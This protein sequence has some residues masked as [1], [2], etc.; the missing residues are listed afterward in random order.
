MTE[1][2]QLTLSAYDYQYVA[3]LALFGRLPVPPKV[4]PARCEAYLYIFDAPVTDDD[5]EQEFSHAV[6]IITR[7][8]QGRFKA[9]ASVYAAHADGQFVGDEET[10]FTRLG[11]AL[12]CEGDVAAEVLDALTGQLTR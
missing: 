2:K 3:E 12:V 8:A 9:T 11:D 5:G 6:A 10:G 7:G 4:D 1:R